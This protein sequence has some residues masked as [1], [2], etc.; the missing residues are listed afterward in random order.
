MKVSAIVDFH[1]VLK[2]DGAYPVILGRPWLTK[3]YAR[4]YWGEGYMTIEVHP[5]KQKVPFTNFVKSSEGTNEYDDE[6]EINQNSNSKR[7]TQ[8]IPMKR[9]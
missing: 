2:E 4:N 6:S 1:V 5:N 7:F 3:S 9:K 8:M